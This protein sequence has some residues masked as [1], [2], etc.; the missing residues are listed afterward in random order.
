MIYLDNAATTFP[1][2]ESVYS[3]MDRVNRTLAVNSGRGAYKSAKEAADIIASTKKLLLKLFNAEGLYDVVFTPSVTHALNQVIG[4]IDISGST[5]IYCSP[6]EHN[7]VARPLHHRLSGAGTSEVLLPLKEDLTVSLGRTEFMFSTKPPDAVFITAVSN[8]TGYVLPVT[9][10]TE[11]A[12]RYGGLVAIDAA[13]AAGLVPM[14]L[15][16][17]PVDII[18]FAGHKTL[19]GPFGIGGFL[20][21]RGT[22]LDSC[23]FGGTGSDSLNLDMPKE[24]PGMYEAS[25]PNITAIAGL[26]AALMEMD[27]EGHYRQVMELTEYAYEKL[28]AVP[29]V[30][31]KGRIKDGKQIGIISFVVDGYRSD[32]V[33]NILD[34]EFDIA[35]R[36]GYH[37]APYIHD[38]LK[39][40]QSGGTVRAGLG[41]FNTKEEIDKLAE[42]LGTL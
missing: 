29:S 23:F 30:R 38:Y 18:C 33:G 12:H 28:A 39:D 7:A 42:A 35:V 2:P 20:I 10:I 19:C 21:R 22:R 3:E 9:G 14:D 24:V 1:K 11:I 41:R 25:S 27:V 8:V 6:Y 37:C 16:K 34:D 32:D 13:Q 40:K 15:R 4:G 31:I 36:T 5:N 26:R 17:M